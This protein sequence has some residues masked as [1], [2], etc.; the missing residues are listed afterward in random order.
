M[1]AKFIAVNNS[2]EMRLE[3]GTTIASNAGEKKANFLKRVI[4]ETADLGALDVSELTVEAFEKLDLAKLKVAK[5]KEKGLLA[6]L[7]GEA[8]TTR[9][10]AL[11]QE[12]DKAKAAKETE[13]AAKKAEK[14]K[15][16]AAKKEAADKAKAEKE[17][18]K[19][20]KVE[21][22]KMTVEQVLEAA[23]AAK[24]N[25][26][27]EVQF[28]AHRAAIADGKTL[29]VVNGVWVD[30]RV[31][32]ALYRI[33]DADGKMYNK[34]IEAADLEFGEMVVNPKAAEK[35]EAKAKAEAEKLA[36][37]EEAE[38]AK[39]EKEAAKI[40]AAQEKANAAVEKATALAK[41]AQ[42]KAEAAAKVAQ[43]KAN[44]LAA[45]ANPT[46]LSEPTE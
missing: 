46:Q 44:A 30:K 36:K 24:E 33:F 6:E 10:I 14:E 17:A 31:P 35:A 45:K 32:M 7:I 41:A 39:A 19:A 12:A 34:T 26:G 23:K 4:K 38:K 5:G 28:I 20:A 8:I 15:A 11:K 42:E 13:A 21:T 25:V 9:E 2:F 1:K 29:G 3:N 18:A 43:E 37:K 16:A 27:K 22:P 40:K